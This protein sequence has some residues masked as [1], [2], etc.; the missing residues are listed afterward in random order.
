MSTKKKSN[1][2]K[3]VCSERKRRPCGSLKCISSFAINEKKASLWSKD[4]EEKPHEVS[5]SSGKEFI[6]DCDK[7]SHSYSMKLN[8]V[9]GNNGCGYCA[10][11]KLCDDSKCKECL[12]KSL[13][14]S[15]RAAF[16]KKSNKDSK[17]NKITPREIF[18]NSGKKYEFECNNCPHSFT[19]KVSS[20]TSLTRNTWCPYCSSSTKKLCDDNDCDHCFNSSFA[21]CKMSKPKFWSKKNGKI[22]PRDL[23]LNSNKKYYFDCNVCSHEFSA[24]L[25]NVVNGKWC[26]KCAGKDCNSKSS[27]KSTSKKKINS[28]SDNDIKS[29]RI[30]GIIK[31]SNSST[32]KKKSTSSIKKSSSKRMR[33]DSSDSE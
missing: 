24:S 2:S 8:H 23:A 4:N 6:F 14:G 12:N 17:G 30:N 5:L 29:K 22:K 20:I 25:D 26:P 21:S 10:N 7:C 33:D 16:F 3:C 13:A 9:N 18:M 32:K 1:G 27:K 15:N 11:Q 31:N 28:D 19:A